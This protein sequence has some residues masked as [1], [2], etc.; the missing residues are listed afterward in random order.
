MTKKDHSRSERIFRAL[1]RLFPFDFRWKHG[2]EM[3]QVFRAQHKEE[4]RQGGTMGTLKL[5]WETLVDIARTAPREHLEMLAQDVRFALRMLRKNLGFTAVA[6]ITLALGIGA[7]TAIF[8]VVNAVLLRPLPYPD[9]DRL[10]FVWET[11][12]D[13][14]LQSAAYL[15]LQE[16][17]QETR[18]FAGL[19][20]M[21][22][23]S[24]NLTGDGEPIRVRGGFVNDSFF[25]VVGVQP[26]MGRVFQKGED[27]AGSELVVVFNHAL[28]KVRYGAD[29][30]ILGKRIL[31]NN[32]AYTVIGVMPEEFRFP[33]DSVEVWMPMHRVTQDLR[34]AWW[35]L[36]RI[37][38]EFSF[39]QAQSE[40]E[41]TIPALQ[42]K[43]PEMNEG[44]GVR[45]ETLHSFLTGDHRPAL[46]LFMG[47]VGLVLL[48]ACANVANLLLARGVSRERELAVRLALGAAR[49]RLVRQ[50]LTETVLLATMGTLLGL[51]VAQ[52][53]VRVF[54]TVAADMLNGQT[55]QLDLSV[56]GFAAMLTVVTGVLFGIAPAMRFSRPDLTLALKEGNRGSGEASR[57]RRLG[58]TLV[59]AQMALAVMLLVGAGLL[60]R[61]FGLLQSIDPGFDTKSLLTLEYRLPRTKYTAGPQITNLHQQVVE[62]VRAIPGVISAAHFKRI[63]FSLNRSYVSFVVEGQPVPP[64]GKEPRTFMNTVGVGGFRTLGIPLLRGRAF[65]KGDVEGPPVV[66]INK[67]FAKRYWED[68]DPIGKRIRLPDFGLTATVIGVVGNVRYLALNEREIPQLYAT[69]SQNPSTFASLAIRVEGDPMN[70]V[71][72][73]REAVWSADKD[74]PMWKFRTAQTM[75]DASLS[76]RRLNMG[77]L[78]SLALTAL[79]LAAIG[80]YGVIAYTVSQRT[81]EIGIRMA[82]GAQ[83]RDVLRM[84]V[85]QGMRLSLV[86]LALGLAGAFALS[87]FLESLLFGVAPTDP[88]TFAGVAF[89]LAAVALL[90]CY[91]PARRAT[92]VDPMVALRYE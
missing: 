40:L 81:H 42:Q 17:R 66:V 29:P 6:V 57:G 77:V 35:N 14:R 5:W 51:A 89:L 86:G 50:L 26:R 63:P 10:V 52:A 36:G 85:G 59:V 33:I 3:E 83:P 61:S 90:A 80:L 25:R 71:R 76:D 82:L 54:T 58:G 4:E 39:E 46:W 73:V 32:E 70:Y 20:G 88:A 87:R 67:T 62:K 21:V 38:P 41:S 65:A 44:F 12:K 75:I 7:N 31:L 2:R 79:F 27:Q 23:Q 34:R 13:G 15:N 92:K 64:K 37:K 68:D 19:T 24:V 43:Y 8:S 72:V 9:P 84:V 28:W 49:I 69:V 18:S 1:L 22:A 53:G 56:L 60:L 55:A 47:A 78:A 74:Q 30:E 11:N 16:W 91:I 48:I 45:L